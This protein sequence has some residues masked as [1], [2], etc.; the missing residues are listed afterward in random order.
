MQKKLLIWH[1]LN[2]SKN[3]YTCKVI[4]YFIYFIK[5]IIFFCK[6]RLL[7]PFLC[8]NKLQEPKIIE[9]VKPVISFFSII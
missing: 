5:N 1:K 4:N 7:E 9:I 6:I 8:V 2:I 3:D